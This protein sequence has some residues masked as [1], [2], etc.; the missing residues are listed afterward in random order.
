MG[1][2]RGWRGRLEEE[3]E[4]GGGRRDGS[5]RRGRLCPNP[6]AGHSYICIFLCSHVL[7]DGNCGRCVS[8]RIV[9]MVVAGGGRANGPRVFNV[10]RR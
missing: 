10:Q 1:E 4:G 6:S 7:V 8:G 2:D 5:I 3:E 9:G